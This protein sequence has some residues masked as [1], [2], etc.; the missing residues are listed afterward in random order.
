[1]KWL[2]PKSL[3][4]RLLMIWLLLVAAYLLIFWVVSTLLKYWYVVVLV[5][6]IYV[7]IRA[8]VWWL[9]DRLSRW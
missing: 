6:V 7:G 9:R 3:A 1:M 8:L 5:I 2:D 4:M